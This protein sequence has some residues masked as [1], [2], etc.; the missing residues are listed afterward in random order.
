MYHG[1]QTPRNIWSAFDGIDCSMGEGAVVDGWL[2]LEKRIDL[3]RTTFALAPPPI[4]LALTCSSP[5]QACIA[6]STSP[7]PA[8]HS[9]S[10]FLVILAGQYF[11]LGPSGEIRTATGGDGSRKLDVSFFGSFCLLITTSSASF[12]CCSFKFVGNVAQRVPIPD[13]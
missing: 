6:E 8:S 1:V 3:I 10:W 4:Q 5:R 2:R 9:D 11:W 13:R 12:C 7:A